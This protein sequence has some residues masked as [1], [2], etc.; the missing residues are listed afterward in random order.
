MPARIADKRPSLFYHKITLVIAFAPSQAPDDSG[1]SKPITPIQIASPLSSSVPEMTYYT[2]LA[3][4]VL[5]FIIV[6]ASK[7]LFHA[8]CIQN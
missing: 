4:A 8:S 6:F 5:T 7:K 2:L 1:T 3:L